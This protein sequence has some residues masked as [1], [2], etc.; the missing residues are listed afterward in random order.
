MKRFLIFCFTFINFVY[1]QDSLQVAPIDTF[2]K[3]RLTQLWEIGVSGNAYK[4][5]LAQ[6]YESFSSALHLGVKFA[7]KKRW[8]AHLN[9]G[10]GSVRGQNYAYEFDENSRPNLFFRANIFTFQ[11][12]LQY[13]FI[14]KKRWIAY[15]SQGLGLMRYMPKNEN[16]ERLQNL[17]TTR[18]VGEIYGN[19]TAILPTSIGGVFLLKNGYG[20]GLQLSWLRPTTDYLDNISA[21]GKTQGADKIF[22]IKG[23]ISVPTWKLRRFFSKEKPQQELKSSYFRKY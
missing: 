12:D 16:G 3:Y 18:A 21:W 11:I 22:L 8:N 10:I 4:G 20:V 2:Q 7:K 19:I 13:N 1:A 6:R 5:D 23:H 15:F 17:L 9:I 14:R